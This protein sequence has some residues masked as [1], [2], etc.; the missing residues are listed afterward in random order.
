MLEPSRKTVTALT[1][2]L[3]LTVGS[4]YVCYI[5]SQ[6]DYVGIITGFGIAWLGYFLFIRQDQ[7][8]SLA[9][10][11]LCMGLLIRV[12]LIFALPNLS[13]D[14]YRFVWD[15]R[16]THAGI[17]PYAYL[18]TVLVEQ[19]ITGLSPALYRELNSP[20]YYSVYPPMA[21]LLYFLSSSPTYSLAT[22]AGILK[23]L[24]IAIELAG[25][26]ALY[27]IALHYYTQAKALRITS[28]YYL[29]PL[30]IVEGVGN[31]HHEPMSMGLLLVSLWLLQ[32]KRYLSSAVAVVVGAGIKLIPVIII[33][34]VLYRLAGKA[35]WHYLLGL[36]ASSTVMAIP[37]LVGLDIA[38]FAESIDLYFRKFEFN[39]SVYYVS[40]YIGRLITGYN[41]IAYIGP[42]LALIPVIFFGK[43]VLH[44]PK[45][46]TTKAVTRYSL[47][48]LSLYYL[49]ATTVHPWYIINLVP[50]AA[51]LGYRY[52]IVWGMLISLT[53]I[54]YSYSP[55]Q[56]NLWVVGLE[57]SVVAIVL[58]WELV[59]KSIYRRDKV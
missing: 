25:A 3:L 19:G 30:V 7:A 13:D 2:L 51:L 28:V 59:T 37:L 12:V 6:S 48:G 23:A 14:L 11:A 39:A 9:V 44:W 35:R 52:A 26:V 36:A 49:C 10:T 47:I 34:F 53:Y 4:L 22:S 41:L 31:L 18:P 16:C 46:L 21:Q 8:T 24:H 42:L 32:T 1:G 17:S 20:D 27:Q 45:E 55:Y 5:P 43:A 38:N 58:Y 29:C 56:E 40:R 54:N 50:L 33:P 15:G 57:Y